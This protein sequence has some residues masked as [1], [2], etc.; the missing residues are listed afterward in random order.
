VEL[1][2]WKVHAYS[3]SSIAQSPDGTQF[4]FVR[5]APEKGEESVFL[6]NLD[7]TNL[8]KLTSRIGL[9]FFISDNSIGPSWSPDGNTIVV[10]AGSSVKDFITGVL[11]IDV[12]SG[13]QSWVGEK[14]WN[15]IHRV[16]WAGDDGLYVIARGSVTSDIILFSNLD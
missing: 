3:Q 16:V 9:E 2:L 11:A 5:T 7:G 10:G 4:A 15:I 12:Q 6:S 13:E 1:L 8:V 14:Q